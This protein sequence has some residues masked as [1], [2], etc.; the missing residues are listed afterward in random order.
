MERT[1]EMM[2]CMKEQGYSKEVPNRFGGSIGF[3]LE[4]MIVIWKI[5]ETES[6]NKANITQRK[7][8]T[9][10]EY[11]MLEDVSQSVQNTNQ[12]GKDGNK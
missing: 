8:L 9:K 7:E 10:E 1:T 11:K 6:I 4:Y 5:L 3:P 12:G 2:I